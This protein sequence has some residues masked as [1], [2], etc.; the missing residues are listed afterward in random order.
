MLMSKCFC[1]TTCHED[2]DGAPGTAAAG[3]AAGPLRAA[4]AGAG[5]AGAGAAGAG[6]GAGGAAGGG[7]VF[8]G[9]TVGG[10]AVTGG[11]VFAGAGVQS[12]LAGSV[13]RLGS[14]PPA[15]PNAA[16]GQA[17]M[18]CS[19]GGSGGQMSL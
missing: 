1:S 9:G 5:A 12:D 15:S 7:I 13:G 11:T 6:A 2:E 19:V 8:S 14:W 18:V 17:G 4:G 10:V 3:W 16:G